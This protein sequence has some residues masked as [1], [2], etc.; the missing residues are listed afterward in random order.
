MFGHAIKGWNFRALFMLTRLLCLSAALSAEIQAQWRST[1]PYGGA[2]ELIRV[3]PQQPEVVLAATR[4][5]L[6]YQSV[7]GGASW[8]DK[9]FPRQLSGVLHTLEVDPK[10]GRTWYAGMED[11]HSWASG[12]YRTTD[13][14]ASW[15]LLPGLKGKAVWSL[16]IWEADTRL[17]AAG[18]ADGVY[19]SSDGGE[20]W[21]PVS[22]ETNRD[23]RPVVSLAFHPDNREI[24]YAGTTHLPWR[25]TDGGAHWLPIHAGMLDDSDVFSIRVDPRRSEIV[26]ASACSGVYRSAS[27]GKL[28]AR[29]P[30]PRGAFRAYFVAP[31]PR[32]AG[33]L[34][35]GTSLGLLKSGNSGAAWRRVST[36]A[37]RSI[38]FDPLRP[39][40]VYFAS[41]TGGLLLSTDG[42]D[43]LR[44][45]N[46]GFS[47]RNLTAFCG[48][49]NVLY[50]ASVYEP[51]TGGLFRS[52]DF[53]TNWQRL[54][55][56]APGKENL[57]ALAASPSD[58]KMLFASTYAELLKS[59]D[60][61]RSWRR[62]AFSSGG[63]R[64]TGLIALPS[65]PEVLM[66]GGGS[67]LFR[68]MDGGL[69]WSSVLVGPTRPVQLLEASGVSVVV[70]TDT[71]AFLSDDAGRSWTACTTPGP[72]VQWY[73][74]ASAAPPKGP[75]L[76]ATSHGLFRSSHG[77]ASWAL[78]REGL[79]AGT[80]SSVV[81]H[82]TRPREAFA[83]QYGKVFQSVDGGEHWRALEDQGRNGFYPS[84]LLILPVAPERLFA[85]F[86]RRGILVHNIAGDAEAALNRLGAG[87]PTISPALI[88][89]RNR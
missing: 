78:V 49:G 66:A 36:H 23:L 3:S 76:A 74:L 33:V 26:Y 88:E 52:E 51:N 54:G 71:G 72:G 56:E 82:P 4:N 79:D 9:P 89:R 70:V 25:T 40:R 30:T 19:L 12:V 60:G 63:G 65:T 47:N 75:V 53:G 86:P 35:A 14:G 59:T 28:W 41:T 8:I 38:A 57:L 18:T 17:I 1:G 77:C 62:L 6:L 37:V 73:A 61:G 34:F 67:G 10:H 55:S 27:G 21:R 7:D 43:T 69:S 83:V 64:V 84:G 31:D 13:N 32:Q 44:E 16:A 87:A 81:M 42:G 68:S 39:G 22:P 15:T 2:A 58:P 46:Q 48:A 85:L 5:G 24:L 20:N 45:I 50:A 80:V 11:E 29:L